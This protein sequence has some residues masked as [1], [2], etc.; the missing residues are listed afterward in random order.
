M[1]DT[2]VE[3]PLASEGHRIQG[4]NA[5]GKGVSAWDSDALAG[6][7][8][9]HSTVSDVLKYLLAY[10]YPHRIDFAA[11]GAA[12]T[13]GAALCETQIPR[14]DS[15]NEKACLGWSFDSEQ[16]TYSHGGA[17]YGFSSFCSFSR[18]DKTAVVVLTNSGPGNAGSMAAGIHAYIVA[19]LKGKDTPMPIDE[20][21]CI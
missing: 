8:G 11:G 16:E 14:A 18:R 19:R 1:Q 17:S 6:A 21:L 9:L 4:R 12:A 3:V 5:K 2:F 13:L 15:L 20:L 7:G 10:I